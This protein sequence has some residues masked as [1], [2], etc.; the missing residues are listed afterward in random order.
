MSQ[1]GSLNIISMHLKDVTTYQCRV[2]PLNGADPKD[3]YVTLFLKVEGKNYI[4][5]AFFRC[6][7]LQL[8]M[9]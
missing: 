3:Y 9:F 1:D 8:T 5:R 7:V 2:T 6:D 4:N